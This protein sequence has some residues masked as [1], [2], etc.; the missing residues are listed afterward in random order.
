MSSRT[1]SVAGTNYPLVLPSVRDARL[2]VAAVIV[3][4]H[5]LGQVALGF[6]VSVPQIL[7]AI[8][9]AGLLEVAVTFVRRQALVWPASAMLTG[10]GVA[11]I[12]RVPSTPQG[13]HWTFHAWYTFAGV[14]AFS[15]ATKYVIRFRGSHVFNPSNIGLVIVFLVL[16]SSRAE[17][18]DFWWAPL[19]FGMAAAY[20]VIVAGGLL[21]ARRLG[22]VGAVVAFWLTLAAGSAVLAASGHC[23]VARWAF[24]PVCGFDYSRVI[25][26]S[27]EVLIF[28]FFMLTDP[29]TVSSGRVGR[30]V[31]GVLVGVACTLLMAPQSNEF[32]AKVALLSG[33]SVMCALRWAVARFVPAPRS[34]ADAIA[35]FARR[36]LVGG[37]RV[38]AGRVVAGVSVTTVALAALGGAVVVA[39]SPA[40]GTVVPSAADVLGREPADVDP[41]TFP[42][43]VVDQEVLDWNHEITGAVAQSIV[44][45][46]VE[47]LE[48]ESRAILDADPAI[49][50]AVDHGARLTAMR[51]RVTS[52][53]ADPRRVVDRYRIDEVRIRLIVPFGEQSGL[54]L[55]IDAVGTVTSEVGVDGSLE[56]KGSEPFA[57]TFVMRRATGDR[58]LTVAVL[59]YGTDP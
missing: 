25:V 23:M 50:D 1:V 26:T 56:P 29:K 30:V 14:A 53:A 39:G 27:P 28:T 52:A 55:G 20:L 6:H 31:F 13:D 37:D 44:L 47:N 58:W 43:I 41:S 2:H 38:R 19:G 16:G 18:L 11:L 15:L 32:G 7:A 8:L 22:F 49:L 51:E 48:L 24:S 35:A 34:G 59:P 40:R 57:T 9:T 17:P 33:L 45:T 36:V 46:L 21:I 54:S 42:S 4:I 12:L 5:V 3:T 10:S